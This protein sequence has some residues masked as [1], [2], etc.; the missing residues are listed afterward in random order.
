MRSLHDIDLRLLRVFKAIVEARGL[1]GAQQVLNLSQS[2]V[3]TQLAELEK[4]LGLRL[5]ARGR[6]G[7]RLTEAG[8]SI[9]QASEDLF[10]A[11][12]CF[13][14]IAWSLSGDMKGILRLGVIDAILSNSQFDLPRVLQRFSER[15]KSVVIDLSIDAPGQMEQ[16]L[17]DNRRDV[18]IGPT[19]TK[20]PNLVF[21]PLFR[22]EKGVFCASTHPLYR[23][24]DVTMQTIR[25]T[26]FA[27]CRYTRSL[28]MERTG[29][30]QSSAVVDHMEA[31]AALILSGNYIGYLPTHFAERQLSEHKLWHLLPGSKLDYGSPFSLAYRRHAEESVV[32]RSFINCVTVELESV[33]AE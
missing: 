11:V 5:C 12:G 21:V 20:S 3:S 32:V 4:R 19:Y 26:P 17:L 18:V 16:L 10:D 1:S 15:A 22:E 2:T 8:K 27:A 14:N 30:Q 33:A 23:R 31:Q 7:F 6:G 24:T 13:Q 29:H 25:E 9:Y 28:D